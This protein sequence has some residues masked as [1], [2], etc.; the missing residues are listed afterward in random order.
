MASNT[1]CQQSDGKKR[2]KPVSLALD[3]EGTVTFRVFFSAARNNRSS[4]FLEM[5][6][7]RNKHSFSLQLSIIQIYSTNFPLRL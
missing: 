6:V 7:L 1:E 5:L 3:L 2:Y 4:M